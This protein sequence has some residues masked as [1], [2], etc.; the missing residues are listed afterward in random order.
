[1]YKCRKRFHCSSDISWLVP[2]KRPLFAYC[3]WSSVRVREKT[4]FT[5]DLLCLNVYMETQCE[6]FVKTVLTMSVKVDIFIF[7]LNERLSRLMANA[8]RSYSDSGL[9]CRTSLFLVSSK[10]NIKGLNIRL[11]GLMIV[12]VKVPFLETVCDFWPLVRV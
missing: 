11:V 8:E 9:S 4:M 2:W 7:I 3:R 1:M 12:N 5:V 6:S 10:K